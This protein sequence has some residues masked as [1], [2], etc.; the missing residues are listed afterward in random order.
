MCVVVRGYV[1]HLL[2][3]DLAI[4][5]DVV[6]ARSLILFDRVSVSLLSERNGDPAKVSRLKYF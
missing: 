6:Y 4:E 3:H 5:V 1:H 2:H